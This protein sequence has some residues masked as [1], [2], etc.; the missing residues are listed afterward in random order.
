MCRYILYKFPL[1]MYFFLASDDDNSV[2]TV[3]TIIPSPF[4][5]HPLSKQDRDKLACVHSAL[6]SFKP[7][8]IRDACIE[9]RGDILEDFPAEIFIQRPEILFS[10]QD[11]LLTNSN[12]A[13][14]SLAAQ[15][16]SKLCNCLEN[17]FEFCV[18]VK[19]SRKDQILLMT[20]Q[21][22]VQ[23]D[24]FDVN[25]D[26]SFADQINTTQLKKLQLQPF[27]FCLMVLSNAVTTLQNTINLRSV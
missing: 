7:E 22:D 14:K 9:F 12:Q 5:W 8:V 15:A 10:L 25:D 6:V 16:L 26:E 18:K 21:S 2:S 27:E 19:S 23:D 1:T 11:I 3:A 13:L 17:R 4:E 24:S 20:G